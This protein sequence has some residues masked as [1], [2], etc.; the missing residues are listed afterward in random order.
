MKS[1]FPNDI[2]VPSFLHENTLRSQGPCLFVSVFNVDAKQAS[3]QAKKL[4]C[5]MLLEKLFARKISREHFHS[6]FSHWKLALSVLEPGEKYS[7]LYG[8]FSTVKWSY[9][10]PF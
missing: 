1:H 2:A 5:E 6:G 9:F 7:G 10:I 8:K 4:T 3:K